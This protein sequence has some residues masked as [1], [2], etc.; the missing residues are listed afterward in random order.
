LKI[1]QTQRCGTEVGATEDGWAIS[2]LDGG[3]RLSATQLFEDALNFWTEF[4]YQNAITGE[5]DNP[6]F[7]PE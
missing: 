3:K 4:I 6:E 2:F 5:W 7:V 1:T